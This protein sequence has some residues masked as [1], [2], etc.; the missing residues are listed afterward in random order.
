MGSSPI[1]G[2]QEFIMFNFLGKR[3]TE[4]KNKQEKWDRRFLDLAKCISSWS[5][6]PST[7]VGA[8][9]TNGIKIVSLGYNGLPKGIPDLPEILNNRQIKYQF[10]IHAEMNAVLTAH[11]NLEGCTI[12][13]H[14]FLPCTRCGSTLAQAGITRVVS[15]KCKDDRW[16]DALKDSTHFMKMCGMEV[17]EY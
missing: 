10:I 13:T 17:V 5:K 14:P 16:K 3:S 6:D 11:T 12:Y 15:K 4:M 1:G 2:T 8:V 7:Q 9:I